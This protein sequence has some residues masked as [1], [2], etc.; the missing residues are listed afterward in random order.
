M[1]IYKKEISHDQAHS[2]KTKYRILIALG[3]N[4]LEMLA[5]ILAK[6]YQYF[7]SSTP[8]LQTNNRLQTMSK[9]IHKALREWDNLEIDREQ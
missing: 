5:G 3:K 2:T 1:K 4:E 7:P 9:V 8:Y 6:A